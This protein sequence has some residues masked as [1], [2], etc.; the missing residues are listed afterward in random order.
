MTKIKSFFV[1]LLLLIVVFIMVVLIALI[2]RANE[3][4]SI[5]TYIFQTENYASE[6]LGNLQ[7]IDTISADDLRNKL[8]KKYV[9]E[10]FKVIPGDEDVTNRLIL[11][12]LSDLNVFKQWVNDEAVK[13]SEMS[14][15]NMFRMVRINDNGIAPLDKT[16]QT[17]SDGELY[18]IVRYTTLTWSEPN[19]MK[20][21]PIQEEN[22]VVLGIEFEPGLRS[23]TNN[24]KDINIRQYLQEGKSPAG[25][26]KFNVK[27]VITKDM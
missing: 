9:S 24:R 6:R 25:L 20:I 10:Y 13:I 21:D 5:K 23:K 4:S 19:I 14:Q 26:F 22:S 16:S 15:K 12:N 27:N 7:D 3:R 2:Y 11:K 17:K 1:G 18:Y 8:I